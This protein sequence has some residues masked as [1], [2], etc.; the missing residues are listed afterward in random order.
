MVSKAR[1]NTVRDTDKTKHC[2]T[3]VVKWERRNGKAEE[4]LKILLLFEKKIR[5]LVSSRH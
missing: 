3:V 1:N 5:T 2:A 4:Y